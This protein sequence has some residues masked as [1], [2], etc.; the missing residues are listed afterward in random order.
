MQFRRSKWI[1]VKFSGETVP[2]FTRGQ[3]NS[4]EGQMCTAMGAHNVAWEMHSCDECC[5]DSIISKVR[6]HGYT[7]T[8]LRLPVR[9]LE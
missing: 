6:V 4:H 5:L 7:R 1:F 9:V 2:A 3:M 8:A